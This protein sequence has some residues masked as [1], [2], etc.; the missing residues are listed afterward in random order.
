[1][2]E[3][4]TAAGP[5]GEFA[6]RSLA[7]RPLHATRHA[8]SEPQR[9]SLDRRAARPVLQPR[10]VVGAADD[11][12][13]REAE[14]AADIAIA[15]GTT[16]TRGHGMGGAGIASGLTA[17]VR[18]AM[19][20]GDPPTRKDG[21]RKDEDDKKKIVQKQSKGGGPS[22]VPARVG[23]SIEAISAAGGSPLPRAVRAT[24]EPRFGFDL[25]G[26]RVH[27]DGPASE[28]TSALGAR[29]FTVGEHVFFG[30]GEYQPTSRQGQWLIA[31]ELAH[32]V[33]QA[34][35][36]RVRRRAIISWEIGGT[37]YYKT[38]GG[39][40]IELP[41]DQT[42]QEVA[43]L[44]DEALAAERRLAELPPPKPVPVVLK[45]SPKP[46]TP[47]AA[48][49][50]LRPKRS[51][52]KAPPKLAD[53]TAALLKAVGGGSV[54]R[55]LV[56]KGAPVFA[57]GATKLSH[58]RANEQTHDDGGEKLR[59]SEDAVVI[60]PSEEQSA[61]NAE[62]VGQVGGRQVP[63][64]DE[65]KGKGTLL[66]SLK[67]NVPRTIGD[68]DN[69]KRDRKAQHTGAAV[70]E[71]VQ[72]DKDSVIATF[73]DL[74]ATPPPA[75][76][77]KEPGELPPP[78]AAPST[79]TMHLGR[80][81]VAP[82]LKEHT[83]VSEYPMQADAKLKEEGVT[84][85]QLDLVDSGDLADANKEKKLM[86]RQAATEPVAVQQ[87][88]QEERVKVDRE[89]DQEE[90]VG[91]GALQVRRRGALA[92]TGQKQ[93]GTKKDLEKKRDD[94]A[95]EINR[96]YT[97]V[98][99]LVKKRLL[100][101][102]VQ[103]M[104]RFDEGN[105]AAARDFENDVN[106]EMA[107]FKDQRYSGWFGWA[108]RVKDWWRGIDELKEVKAIFETNKAAFE[109]RIN[110]LV[111]EISADN[112]RV[113][114]E[115]HEKL[116]AERIAIEDFVHRLPDELQDMGKKAAGE[117]QEKLDVLD[118][119]IS[120][121]E[122][123]LQNKL[124]DKQTAAIKAIDEK[125]AKMKESMS[126]ALAKVGRLLLKAAKKF[127]SWALEKFGLSLSTIE[128]II[129]KGI[130]VLKAIFT[131]PIQFVKNLIAAAKLGFSN[132][133]KNFVTHLKDAVFEWL[134]GAIEGVTLPDSW[135]VRGIVSV[136]FQIIGI[137]WANLKQRLVLL[138]PAPVVEGLQTTFGLV[139]TLVSEGPM[140]AWEQLKEM[141]EELKRTFVSAVTDWIKWKVVEEAV[142]TVLALFI[143][144]AGMV[145]AIV[146]IYD[147][148]VFFIQ[149]ARDIMQMIGSFLGSI[150]EIAAGNIGAAADALELGLARG[151][152]LVIAFL[153]KFLR[154]DGITARIRTALDAVRNKVNAVL[155]KVASWVVGLAKKAGKLG[156]R[157]DGKADGRSEESPQWA[158][159]V[160][161]VSADVDAMPV[162]ERNEAGFNKHLPAWKSKWKFVELGV[163][164]E[165]GELV[166]EGSMSPRRKVKAVPDDA[167]IFKDIEHETELHMK[168]SKGGW[169]VVRVVKVEPAAKTVD[170]A[171]IAPQVGKGTF[172]FSDYGRLWKKFI[173]GTGFLPLDRLAAEN[174]KPG[175]WDDRN[176]ARLVLNYRSNED[177]SQ[178]NPAGKQWHHIHEFS[179]GGPNSVTNL[180]L[181]S[182][183]NNMKF[184]EWFER[185]QDQRGVLERTYPFRLRDYL[186][187]KDR[188]ELWK[189]WGYACLEFHGVNDVAGAPDPKGPWRHI[190][191]E[192][193]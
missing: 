99:D 29:A 192:G 146:A 35:P 15:G 180:V 87:M 152:K 145:R 32:V 101:L 54:A 79:G 62:Q 1:V 85:E 64:V 149:K 53:A 70:L 157:A 108:K 88:A 148:I 156:E 34:P 93:K 19:G 75:P 52:G 21:E 160:R 193:R 150:A 187:E 175:P 17:V 24:F 143:P 12:Y 3:Q 129:D 132:F 46:A 125:I 137:S 117:M 66:Q 142:K 188:P 94:V 41:E 184:K 127:F 190:P 102:D 172:R 73:G 37:R 151:L 105:A 40:I 72:G 11:P 170:W 159:A 74:R 25:A 191:K 28:A 43:K 42:A 14:R 20:K 18:R 60:P 179:G 47:K 89:L 7:S 133:A 22:A 135:T 71:V 107:Q 177:D 23:T 84:Q 49:Q 81:T 51:K 78:E 106:R 161:G 76:S 165:K 122:E 162:E 30:A 167:T 173:P 120:R 147:T 118:K 124:K 111:E 166:V 36:D 112:A 100:D 90:R 91:R 139:K 154:L 116:T 31:H 110:T 68:L 16:M 131:G 130:A 109:K 181:T 163:V 67:A 58:L 96:R 185:P 113:I 168:T 33:Q 44:E 38:R 55:Y 27:A 138:I 164:H 183:S 95:N 26:V 8:E 186:K 6:A 63:E 158:A 86:V 92:A 2:A 39:E 65:N 50:R 9:P 56:S 80:G 104:K 126:G 69:F 5:R 182:T 77:T 171:L 98:Q 48:K 189:A 153:A 169:R 10:L 155:D 141:G 103:S 97:A 144:G 178:F 57:Q 123:E 134:T 176:V 136:L 4:L 13:E 114:R 140:A 115:C 61:S 59:K 119:D 83:D 174:A 128:S 45:P 82:L 121:K